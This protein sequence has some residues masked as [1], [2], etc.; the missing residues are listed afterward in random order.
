MICSS[1]WVLLTVVVASGSDSSSCFSIITSENDAADGVSRPLGVANDGSFSSGSSRDIFLIISS[2]C[3]SSCSF[4]TSS[5]SSLISLLIGKSRARKEKEDHRF[6]AQNRAASKKREWRWQNHLFLFQW[7]NRVTFVNCCF[8]FY[9]SFFC[10]SSTYSCSFVCLLFEIMHLF[11]FLRSTERQREERER[12]VCTDCWL[13]TVLGGERHVVKWK[14]M[15]DSFRYTNDL[16][17]TIHAWQWNAV[18]D[19]DIY[20]RMTKGKMR[21]STQHYLAISLRSRRASTTAVRE[22]TPTCLRTVKKKSILSTYLETKAIILQRCSW[23]EWL[24][25]DRWDYFW[26]NTFVLEVYMRIA[27]TWRW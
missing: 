17:N 22:L 7:T 2:D 9:F 23:S 5:S 3:S 24:S 14:R 4:W 16:L 10:F 26:E 8:F 18:S 13:L 12:K 6:S 21:H 27:D 1:W 11:S 20:W 15:I 25:T 19:N